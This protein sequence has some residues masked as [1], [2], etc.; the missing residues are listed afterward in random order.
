[1]VDDSFPIP[2]E[3]PHLGGEAPQDLYGFEGDTGVLLSGRDTII[4]L[5]EALD[6]G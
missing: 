2:P 6:D 1:M 5:L 4:P 3:R